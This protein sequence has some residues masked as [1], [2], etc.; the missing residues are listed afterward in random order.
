[1]LSE[2]GSVQHVREFQTCYQV[3]RIRLLIRRG[4]EE[5]CSTG[6]TKEF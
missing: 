4:E 2:I 3:K 5:F 6:H 1:M